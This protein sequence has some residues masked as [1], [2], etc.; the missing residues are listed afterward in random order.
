M[1]SSRIDFCG[2][3]RRCFLLSIIL[4]CGIRQF[5]SGQ[6]VVTNATADSYLTIAQSPPLGN[7]QILSYNI[8]D[9][10]L[11]NVNASNLKDLSMYTQPELPDVAYFMVGTGPIQLELWS[12]FGENGNTVVA[13]ALLLAVNDWVVLSRNTSTTTGGTIATVDGNDTITVKV[14]VGDFNSDWMAYCGQNG[15]K[16]PDMVIL[17]TTQVISG[18]G[19]DLSA[20][21]QNPLFLNLDSALKTLLDRPSCCS[22]HYHATRRLFYRVY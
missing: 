20:A 4:F 17:G 13:P 14:V 6:Q 7:A 22:W 1:I 15:I 5:I 18:L 9:E 12:P 10:F 11:F 21:G 19:F 3:S 16:C 2:W 8:N